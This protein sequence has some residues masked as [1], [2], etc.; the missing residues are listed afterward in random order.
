MSASLGARLEDRFAVLAIWSYSGEEHLGF[1]GEGLEG[2]RIANFGEFNRCEA[3][4]RVSRLT[5]F[6]NNTMWWA[7]L[8]IYRVGCGLY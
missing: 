7:R 2:L 6:E 1:D 3:E 5:K 8:S 4:A